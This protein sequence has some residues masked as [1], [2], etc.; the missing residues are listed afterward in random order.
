M[1]SSTA[2]TANCIQDLHIPELDQRQRVR[3]RTDLLRLMRLP[4][5]ASVSLA[6]SPCGPEDAVCGPEDPVCGPARQLV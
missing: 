5:P 6:Y 3:H 2:Q 1:R 4:Q